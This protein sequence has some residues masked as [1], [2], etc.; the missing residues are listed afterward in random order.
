M[1]VGPSAEGTASAVWWARALAYGAAVL[2]ALV[3]TVLGVKVG[4]WQER[5]ARALA[6]PRPRDPIGRT[7]PRA[8]VGGLGQAPA[9]SLWP[10]LA[11]AID[12]TSTAVGR[13]AGEQRL[14]AARLEAVLASLAEGVI[15]ADEQRRVIFANPV[16]R[17]LLHLPTDDPD[18]D[19]R[20]PVR[21]PPARTA[22]S[23]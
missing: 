9:D 6:S 23:A 2:G 3:A 12:E 17:Q 1:L 11:A 4:G 7:Y 19:R 15:V 22:P 10:E 13:Q 5:R 8:G 20:R 21:R 18:A 14:R 16:A